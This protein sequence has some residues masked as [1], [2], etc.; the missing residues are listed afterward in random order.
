MMQPI[1][2]I[3]YKAK[4]E[5]WKSL[6]IAAMIGLAISVLFLFRAI[7]AHTDMQATFISPDR[8]VAELVVR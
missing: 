6:A 3:A 5:F 8:V 2:R 1:P 7:K 4:Y